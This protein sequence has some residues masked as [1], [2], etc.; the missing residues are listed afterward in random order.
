MVPDARAMG[1]YEYEIYIGYCFN[2][3]ATGDNNDFAREV[4]YVLTRREPFL[5]RRSFTHGK[6]GT[7]K[8]RSGRE[9]KGFH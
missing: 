4:A 6:A 5:A 9:M 2:S 3:L 8:E 7:R 1:C